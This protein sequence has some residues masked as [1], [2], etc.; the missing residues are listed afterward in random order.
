MH[1]LL[2]VSESVQRL[3][4]LLLIP[5]PPDESGIEANGF[6]SPV[7]VLSGRPNAFTAQDEDGLD[8]RC[9]SLVPTRRSALEYCSGRRGRGKH[10]ARVGSEYTQLLYDVEKAKSE[11]CAFVDTLQ[12][13]SAPRTE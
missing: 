3:E 9:A 12:W 4:G 5:S 6:S 8:D 11:G 13:V 1:L 10:V 7:D 2:K